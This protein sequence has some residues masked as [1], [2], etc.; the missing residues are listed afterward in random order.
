MST[1][2]RSAAVLAG[3]DGV[4]GWEE[5]FYRDLH[6]H[7]ELSHQEHRTAAR[8]AERLRGTGFSVHEGVGGTGVVAVM[9]NGDGPT[10]LLRADMDALPVKEA[11]GLAYASTTTVTDAAGAEI[12]VMHACGHDVHVTCLLGAAQLLSDGVANWS[13]TAVALFQPAEEVGDGARAMVEDH[14]SELI[15]KVDVALAQHVLPT[16]AGVVG[17]HSGPVLSVADSMR[18]TVHGRGGH[19]SMPQSTVDPVVLAAMIVVRLQTVISRETAPG[20]TAVLTVGSIA[21]GTKSNVISDHAVLQLNVRTYSDAVRTAILDAIHRIVVG[22]CHASGSPK[23]PEFELFDHFPLTD[24]DPDTTAR[25][26]AAFAAHFGD[27]NTTMP[28]WTAS[29]DFSDI[30]TALGVPYTYWGFGGIDPDTYRKAEQAGRVSQDIPVNHSA[31][32]APVLQPTL[33]TGT[34]A[35][36]VAALAWL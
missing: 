30:P 29:E 8:V 28:I 33:D 32:F 10:V 12:P 3:L 21:A 17:T 35:L 11:T 22:E 26:A 36:V 1:N 18:I 16:P 20:E 9:R 25:V 23:D 34:E 24:N 2:S 4:R 14:L 19:G 5:E 13:G 15:P 7:P 27:R 31:A 6:Q